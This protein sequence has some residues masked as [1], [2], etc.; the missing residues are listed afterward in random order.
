MI[1]Y[2]DTKPH[3]LAATGNDDEDD[4]GTELSLDADWLEVL[5]AEV[6]GRPVGLLQI[7]DPLEEETHYWG[8]VEANLRAIDI[9]IGEEA[10]LG[11]GYGSEMMRLALDRCFSEPQVT[12]VLIDPLATNT[13]AHRFYERLGFQYVGAQ[14]FGE[15][16]CI[17]YRL[18]R[19]AWCRAKKSRRQDNS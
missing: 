14:R 15:D 12:A 11:R 8:D 19:D 5:V 17:V 9:W 6:D 16:D 2:W 1:E 4:W 13:R 7:I 10:D 3:V 18:P